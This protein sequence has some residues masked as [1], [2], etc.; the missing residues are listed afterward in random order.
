MSYDEVLQ[1]KCLLCLQFIFS[2][3]LFCLN[4]PVL[5]QAQVLHS[6]RSDPFYSSIF[7]FQLLLTFPLSATFFCSYFLHAS[8]VSL[9][10]VSS[11]CPQEDAGAAS[12]YSPELMSSYLKSLCWHQCVALSY[13][14]PH[15]ILFFVFLS[16]VPL[17]LF[18]FLYILFNLTSSFSCLTLLCTCSISLLSKYFY[19]IFVFLSYFLFSLGMRFHMESGILSYLSF[20]SVWF[21]AIQR[22]LNRNNS[23][24]PSA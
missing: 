10:N 4:Y 9:C 8:R 15:S 5:S 18:K 14:N 7:T 6:P 21:P 2:S 13:P 17:F 23:M 16:F 19:I 3:S 22:K 11:H 24:I 1:G 20:I 12:T